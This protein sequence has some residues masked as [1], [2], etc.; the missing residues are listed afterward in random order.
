[1]INNNICIYFREILQHLLEKNKIICYEGKTLLTYCKSKLDLDIY[2]INI[3]D[4]K[5]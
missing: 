4:T 5:V 3:I 1:M 2:K